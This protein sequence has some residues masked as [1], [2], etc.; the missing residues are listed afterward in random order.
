MECVSSVLWDVTSCSQ[1]E[2]PNISEHRTAG[3]SSICGLLPPV[4]FLGALLETDDGVS[5]FLR[6]ISKLVPH[7]TA[8]H[9]RRECS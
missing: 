6:N 8:S 5:T 3:P 2:V 4:Y 7:Y 9:P 1:V